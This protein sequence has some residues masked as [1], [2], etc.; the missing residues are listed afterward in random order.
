MPCITNLEFR[1]CLF[2]KTGF[3]TAI[4]C[5]DVKLSARG[6]STMTLTSI[7]TLIII[8]ITGVI[9]SITGRLPH[10]NNNNNNN[11]LLATP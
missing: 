2:G 4:N 1:L 10:N 7:A 8:S 11:I 9:W 3:L 5:F 6:Q